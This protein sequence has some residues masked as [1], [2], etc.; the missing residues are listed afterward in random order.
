MPVYRAVLVAPSCARIVKD[1]RLAVENF[2]G[3]AGSVKLRVHTEYVLIEGASLPGLLVLQAESVADSM[4][5][6][7]RALVE[8]ALDVASVLTFTA[9]A[10]VD[11]PQLER[12]YDITAGA[13][14]RDFY[15]NFG[16]HFS[17][18]ERRVRE[19]PAAET[20]ALLDALVHHECRNRILRAARQY[21]LALTYWEPG[22]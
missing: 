11:A 1:S 6:A 2:P 8:A 7:S 13:Q 10:T 21:R 17:D 4:G 20:G 12:A 5:P 9:N 16:L 19:V 3:R 22:L 15:K 18:R 14:G